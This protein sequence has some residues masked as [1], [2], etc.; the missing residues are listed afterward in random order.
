MDALIDFKERLRYAYKE[1]KLESAKSYELLR[2]ITKIITIKVR[3]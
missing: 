3:R 2:E 1:E